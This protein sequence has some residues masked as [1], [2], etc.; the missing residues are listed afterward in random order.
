M[1]FL[2]ALWA[3]AQSF[4]GPK[5]KC[6]QACTSSGGSLENPFIS[7]GCW[8]SMAC[9]HI[10]VSSVSLV[11]RLSLCSHILNVFLSPSHMD[12]GDAMS[13][14]LIKIKCSH[15]E[16][17]NEGKIAVWKYPPCDSTGKRSPTNQGE[18]VLQGQ[19]G[20][21]KEVAGQ[22]N[23]MEKK[24]GIREKCK[25]IRRSKPG[26]VQGPR[27]LYHRYT[28]VGFVLFCFETASLYIPDKC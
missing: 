1:H 2:I 20:T 15:L 11:H 22:I 27:I 13:G 12:P 9:G 18:T 17:L 25:S 24:K 26:L 7:P 10:T 19:R 16:A 3:R 28:V 5:R 21:E 8:H 23:V 6:C 4:S 14:P